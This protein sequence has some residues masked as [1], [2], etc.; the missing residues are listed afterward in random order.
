MTMEET[1]VVVFRLEAPFP[2]GLPMTAL[3][4]AAFS[5]V[6][7]E[8]TRLADKRGMEYAEGDSPTD[9]YHTVFEHASLGDTAVAEHGGTVARAIAYAD[10]AEGWYKLPAAYRALVDQLRE[11]LRRPGFHFSITCDRANEKAMRDAVKRLSHEAVTYDLEV[12]RA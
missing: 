10:Q 9:R 4:V 7:L 11:I 5:G 3:L 2:P 12:E 8:A 1:K 6:A